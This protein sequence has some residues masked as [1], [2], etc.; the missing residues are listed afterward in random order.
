MGPFCAPSDAD[1]AAF[2]RGG[3]CSAAWGIVV[4]LVRVI[5]VVGE[6]DVKGRAVAN[7][8]AGG[9]EWGFGRGIN[10]AMPRETERRCW[11]RVRCVAKAVRTAGAP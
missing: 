8:V 10:V 6:A 1:D 5:V 4:A 11:R 3:G 2:P 9:Q 7:A